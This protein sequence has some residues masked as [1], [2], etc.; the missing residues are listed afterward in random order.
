[1][2]DMFHAAQIA[3]NNIVKADLFVFEKRAVER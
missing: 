3:N 1:M 2:F